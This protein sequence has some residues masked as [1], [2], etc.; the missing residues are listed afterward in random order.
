MKKI[1]FLATTLLFLISCGSGKSFRSFFNNYKNDMGVT[2]FQVPNFMMS[3]AKNISPEINNLLGNVNDFKFIT[4]GEVSQAK[5]A[6][7]IQDINAVTAN[8]FTDILRSNQLEKTKIVSVK[9]KGDVVSQ[10]II[11]NSTKEKTTVFYLKGNF[12]PN[13]IKTLSE[14]NQFEKLSSKLT[15]NYQFSPKTP[16]FINN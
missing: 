12:D 9:E 2:A 5:Q 1:T 14:T 4:F 10:A 7:I 6:Q 13:R 3:L 8:N 16:G 11:F 15:Q